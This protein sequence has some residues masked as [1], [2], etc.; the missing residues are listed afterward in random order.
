MDHIQKRRE[1]LDNL[2]TFILSHQEDFVVKGTSRLKPLLQQEVADHLGL[3]PS[4]ISRIVSSK[5][6]DTPHGILP[7]K[8]LCPRRY[9]GKTK[10]RLHQ[11]IEDVLN[12]N[13]TLSDE[14]IRALLQNQ[15]IDIAR[16]TVA[17]YRNELGIESSFRRK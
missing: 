17:K 11:L 15:H 6:I 13:P 12:E 5:Y 7:F 4:T 10:E 14:K 1:N 2:A 3:S 16:R 8:S 9:F